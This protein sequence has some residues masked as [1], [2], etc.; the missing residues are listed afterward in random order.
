MADT[1]RHKLSLLLIKRL[2]I[3]LISIKLDFY[4]NVAIKKV[5]F[6]FKTIHT[7]LKMTEIK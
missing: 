5:T 2:N 7:V 1:L 4:M 6:N 3:K